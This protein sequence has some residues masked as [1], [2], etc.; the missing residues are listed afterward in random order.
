MHQILDLNVGI[1]L[2]QSIPYYLQYLWDANFRNAVFSSHL[3]FTTTVIVLIP[4]S[5]HNMVWSADSCVL[6]QRSFSDDKVMDRVITTT[7]SYNLITT[8]LVLII[9]SMIDQLLSF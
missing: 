7:C 8:R 2:E 9:G 6:N 5:Y 4:V 1:S 3:H